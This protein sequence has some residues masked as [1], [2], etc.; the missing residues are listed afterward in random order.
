MRMQHHLEQQIQAKSDKF[1]FGN[2]S[3]SSNVL[4]IRNMTGVAEEQ[5]KEFSLN[6]KLVVCSFSCCCG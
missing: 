5:L 4:V 1:A 3:V 6:F 2:L